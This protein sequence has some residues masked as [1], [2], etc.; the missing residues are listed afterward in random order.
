MGYTGPTVDG[1]SHEGWVVPLFAGGVEGAGVSGGQGILVR[2]PDGREEWRPDD[3]VTGW[4]AGCECGWRGRPWTRVPVGGLVDRSARLLAMPG[5]YYD[6]DNDDEQLVIAEWHEHVAPALAVEA[7]AD[8]AAEVAAATDRLDAAV[9]A[10]R[11]AGASWS[12]VGRGAGITRQSAN[13]RWAT[14]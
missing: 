8:A 6:L 9:R 13:E 11:T 5:K 14:R 4:A 10:A 12:D 3:E 1:V 2:L 7:I